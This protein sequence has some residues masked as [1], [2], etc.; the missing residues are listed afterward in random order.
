MSDQVFRSRR[1]V[2]PGSVRACSI[3]V[4]QGRVLRIAEWD[5][6]PPDIPLHDAGELVILP[7][8]VDTH[9]HVNEPGRTEWEGFD[10]ATR[11]AAAGG[12][13]T[14]FDMPLNSI[15][16]TTDIEALRA[17]REAASGRCWID[18]GFLGGVVPGNQ[19]ELT[20]LWRAGVAAFK[21]FLIDSGVP[22][23][24]AVDEQDLCDALPRLRQLSARLW[25][26]AEL[27]APMRASEAAFQALEPGQR[28]AYPRYLQSRPDAGELAAIDLLLRLCDRYQNPVHVVHLATAQ[29]LDRLESARAAGLAV[30][31][32][33][34]P[35]Y[36]FFAAEEIPDGATEYKCA[37]PIRSQVNRDRLWAG[38]ETGVI[39]MI[40]S[41]HSPS[42]P[43]RKH[44]E[45]GDFGAAW[46]GV[47]SLQLGLAAVW[48]QARDRGVEY[49]RLADWMSLAPAKLAGLEGRKGEIAV[50]ADADLVFW[51]PE[52]TWTVDAER[53]H[54]R[55]KITPY[56]GRRLR[57]SVL[58]TF[59]RGRPVFDNGVFCTRPLG[60]LLS[61]R[62]SRKSFQGKA[63]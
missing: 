31:V 37:P 32:E 28:R 48:T 23:F 2:V 3:H 43:D 18:V 25:A 58:S 50:G 8:L 38:L 42:P 30:S 51:D 9:V 14:L 46:G 53:L 36:L 40:V 41:D 47:A 10:C 59:L 1:V 44:L 24:P 54:H 45:S 22:E 29:A 55:H 12:V 13:T 33:T 6:I 15:P 26:H 52:A 63:G 35:H 61:I 49:R 62:D 5:D 17:K 21:C 7:G 34:C 19:N 60:Q 11:A 20:G 4:R 57:G 56:H 39:D 16:A 27:A